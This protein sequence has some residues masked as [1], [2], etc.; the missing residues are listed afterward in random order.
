MNWGKAKSILIALFVCADIFLL[1][2]I[3]FF[4]SDIQKTPDNV[5]QAASEIIEKGGITVDEKF[6]KE[7]PVELQIPEMKSVLNSA[8]DFAENILGENTSKNDNTFSSEKG[9]LTVDGNY[10]EFV[11]AEQISVSVK[12]PVSA[13]KKILNLLAVNSEHITSTVETT[14]NGDYML[15]ISQKKNNIYYFCSEIKVVFSEENVK[16]ISGSWFCEN[17]DRSAEITTKPI[18]GLLVD[19]SLRNNGRQ[20][21]ITDILHGY[22]LPDNVGQSDFFP[23]PCIKIVF[24]DGSS[25]YI[26]SAEKVE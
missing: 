4:S 17:S 15:V 21:K 10:F 23:T 16:K 25:E 13:A 20:K 26:P 22:S 18:S 11:P 8:D 1:S 5:T 9:T 3:L 7:P 24:S 19:Y 6:L 14:E 2:V 12:N